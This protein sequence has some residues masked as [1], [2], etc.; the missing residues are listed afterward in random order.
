MS[1]KND[2]S[3][4][5]D[6]ASPSGIGSAEKKKCF[7]VTPIGANDSLTRRATDGLINTVIRPALAELDFNVYVAHE[8]AAPGSITKQVIEHLLYDD[9][10]VANLTG[11]NPNV[12]YELA[13]R[14]AARLPIVTV[15]EQDTI[16]PFDISDERTIFFVND[17][18][19]ARELKPRLEEAVRAA[20]AELE[21]D[22]PIYRVAEARVMRDVVA[23]GDTEKYL[24]ERLDSI[25]NA[26]S[27]MS[28]S[29][30][31]RQTVGQPIGGYTYRIY[32]TNGDAEKIAKFRASIDEKVGSLENWLRTA[33]HSS[34]IL[35]FAGEVSP[36]ELAALAES[37]GLIVRSISLPSR[38]A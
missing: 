27:R 7:V 16:L 10:V 25:E 37:E 13:V 21:P 11:L 19:G 20:V 23:K 15:A 35:Q 34:L 33:D 4:R 17:M 8:I 29:V 1:A 26:V 3:K 18:E 9:L 30:A 6:A 28:A 24:L 32:F 5:V 12:M 22:N 2:K 38:R 31:S 36:K 14:H